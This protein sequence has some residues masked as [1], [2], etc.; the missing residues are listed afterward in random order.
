V[1]VRVYVQPRASKNRIVGVHADELKIAVT[2]PP[3]ED[4]ANEA[5]C[6]LL[7]DFF[8]VPKSSAT[9]KSGRAS[10]HKTIALRGV[11]AA[12]A[13]ARLKSQIAQSKIPN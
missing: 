2:A 8:G 7:A 5:A 4:A 6:R 12:D 3:V 9:V 10:R 11:T 1:L 13:R